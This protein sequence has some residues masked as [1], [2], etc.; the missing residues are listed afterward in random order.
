MKEIT[1]YENYVLEIWRRPRQRHMHL[2]VRPDGQ[3]RVTCNKRIAKR[4]IFTFL[5]ESEGFIKNCLLKI[6]EQRQRFPAKQFTTGEEFLFLGQRLP[7]QIIWSWNAK[8][9]IRA[10]EDQLEMVAPLVSSAEER[11]KA[12]FKFMQKQA[13]GT[14]TERV[15][16]FAQQM[17]L[18][19][20]TLS[21]RGQRTRW[22]SCSSAG[23][24]NLNWKLMAA[25]PEVIDYVVV[26]ELAHLR[27][28]NHSTQ[29]WNLVE[30]F[31]PDHHSAKRW[32]RAH[33]FEIGV[34]FQAPSKGA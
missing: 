24:V 19:P 32:L 16:F 4:E 27:Y 6:K 14:L 9:Q 22:G 26:H 7:L 29:F 11:R 31:F 15:N 1:Q 34:Q 3:L 17:N 10:L 5:R 8:V 13:R 25:L 20:K 12:V 28:M 23:K 30:Q 2:R 18:Y 21:I 33:E